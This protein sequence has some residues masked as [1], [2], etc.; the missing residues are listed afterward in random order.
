MSE[1][2][3]KVNELIK[4][5]L[6]QILSSEAEFPLGSLVTITKVQT[7]IDLKSAR[8][9]VSV[10][11]ESAKQEAMKILIRGAK[12][13]RRLINEKIVLRS[14]PRLIFFLDETESKAVAIEHLLDNLQ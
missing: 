2:I 11:P 6:G 14:I 8:I 5:Q 9:Y 4:Q 7:S 3:V 1:R 10:F 13:F 12:E